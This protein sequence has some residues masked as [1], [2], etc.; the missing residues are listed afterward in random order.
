VLVL[1]AKGGRLRYDPG[2]RRWFQSGRSGEHRL[3]EDPFHQARDEMHSLT[4][5]LRAQPGWRRWRPSYGYGVAFPDGTYDRDAHPAAPARYAIDR[6]DM[7]DLSDRVRSIMSEWRH[8]GRAF[9]SHGMRR[10]RRRSATGW[11]SAHP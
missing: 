2:T 10:C 11:R 4:R 5:I 9:G 6:G 1:E 7:D 8:E 3:G